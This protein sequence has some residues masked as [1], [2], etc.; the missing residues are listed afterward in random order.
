MRER[1]LRIAGEA[2]IK[3]GIAIISSGVIRR[4]Q[5]IANAR[6]GV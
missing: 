3:E 5:A 6:N 1:I 2:L 4:L